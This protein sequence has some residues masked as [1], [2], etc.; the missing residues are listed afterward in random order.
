MK[1]KTLLLLFLLSSII[2]S[3]SHKSIHQLDQ[4][5]YSKNIRENSKS[6]SKNNSSEAIIP[7]NKNKTK[8]L[9]KAVFGYFPDWEY[10]SDAQQN[11][12]Y[13]LLSHIAIFDFKLSSNGSISDPSSWPWTDF[14][15]K[16]H[17]NGIKLIMAVT[18]FNISAAD[19]HN[20]LTSSITKWIFMNAVKSKIKN[21]SLDGVNIDFEA[22]NTADRGDVLNAFMQ[23]LTDTVHAIS[24]DLEVSFAAPAVNWG[25]W[26]L[27]NLAKSCDYLFVMG[28][29][30]YGSWSTTTGPTA[31]L[32]GGSYNVT[33]TLTVQYAT[34][35]AFYP[36]KIILG[37][38]YYGPSWQTSTLKEGSSVVKFIESLRFKNAQ[39]LA[40][41]YGIKWSTAFKNSWYSYSQS[42]SNYQVWFDNDSSLALKFDLAIA[43]KLKGVGMWA[44]GYDGSRPEFWN[45]IER[46]FS[47]PVAINEEKIVSNFNLYQNYPNPF[48]PVTKIKFSIP[49]NKSN[50]IIFTK[51]IVYD[52]L[53]NQI[54]T[55]VDENK[56]PGNYEVDFNASRL[57]SG[58]Y[59]YKLFFADKSISKKMLILK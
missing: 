26:N 57:S 32:V 27:T 45:L 31:P 40:E 54:E 16:S 52:I 44:L 12:N 53:G 50:Q 23:E 41:N 36:E 18:N 13:D 35:T 30:F 4:E 46:K 25:G 9:S 17:E 15:N 24:P 8:N 5:K 19:L 39:P 10:D 33:N 59:F 48:N 29:D 3:Q 56:S 21:Y 43:K 7:I 14:I 55:L 47:I 49:S 1:L 51:L 58:V 6:L 22:I 37:V 34:V 2:F 42:S 28:Y 38:P 20:V 11:F